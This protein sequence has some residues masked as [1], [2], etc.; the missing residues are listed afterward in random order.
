[1]NKALA[2]ELWGW[3]IGATA[4]PLVRESL[5]PKSPTQLS[6]LPRAAVLTHMQRP[7]C[8]IPATLRKNKVVPHMLVCRDKVQKLS[9]HSC[10]L[11]GRCLIPRE[12]TLDTA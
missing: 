12:D 9:V 2:G 3:I 1:M 8:G 6:I 5:S 4:A 11:E 7:F 10:G